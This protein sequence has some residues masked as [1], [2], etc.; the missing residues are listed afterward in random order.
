[1]ILYPLNMGIRSVFR[2]YRGYKESLGYDLGFI[3]SRAQ[4][5]GQVHCWVL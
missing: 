5:L 3:G 2:V 1:M 4:G